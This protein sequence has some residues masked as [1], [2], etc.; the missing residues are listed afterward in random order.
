MALG[1]YMI[2]NKADFS[3]NA[4]IKGYL[5]LPDG[6]KVNFDTKQIKFSHDFK[7]SYTGK[8]LEIYIDKGTTVKNAFVNLEW[9][10][11]PL[12]PD[13]RDLAKNLSVNVEW[14]NE[15]GKTIDPSSII[16]GTTFWGHF[17]VENISGLDLQELALTQVF[18]AGW[19]IENTRLSE[20]D[21][22]AWMAKYKLNQEKYFD[23]RDDRVMWFFDLPSYNRKIE[24]VVR[25][26]AITEGQFSLAPTVSEA[27]YDRNYKAVKAGKKVTVKSR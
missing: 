13:E 10:G 16:Q 1:K 21:A 7:D 8:K 19:E 11:I 2:Q 3:G 4:V 6:K 23:I 9:N 5:L 22:P 26:N 18:P 15:N 25:I 27:M 17:T 20:D 14:L 12:H 24:F